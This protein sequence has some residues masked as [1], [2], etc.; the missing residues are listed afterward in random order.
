[1][2]GPE[3]DLTLDVIGALAIEM[4]VVR[5]KRGSGRGPKNAVPCYKEL[6]RKPAAKN[7]FADPLVDFLHLRQKYRFL[8]ESWSSRF[9]ESSKR[10]RTCTHSLQCAISQCLAHQINSTTRIR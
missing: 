1:M 3:N 8:D 5:L 4:K 10:N 6:F 2:P 7:I 9:P